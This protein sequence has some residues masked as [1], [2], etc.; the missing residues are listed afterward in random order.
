MINNDSSVSITFPSPAPIVYPARTSTRSAFTLVELLVVIAIIG[1]L[2]G[3]LL[4]A[5]QS[6]REA[7][8][9]TVCSNNMRQISLALALHESSRSEF[10]AGRNGCST[11]IGADQ[12]TPENPCG[13][14]TIPNPLCGASGFV[15]VLPFIEQT[16]LFNNLEVRD[17]GLWVDDISDRRWWDEAPQ[18][19]RDAMMF[20]PS[21]FVC[22]SSDSNE[23]SDV[24]AAIATSA[25]G[26]YA[27]CNGS[28][29]PDSDDDTVKYANDGLFLY[30]IP[31]RVA[32]I[33]QG[34]SNTYQAG[35]VNDSDIWESSSLWT[36]G[37][38]HADSLRSTRNPL[39]SLPGEGVVR[40][41]RNGA[42]GSRHPGGG[43]FA[44]ADGHVTFVVDEIESDVYQNAS[45]ITFQ[46]SP[47]TF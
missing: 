1:I 9:Q 45:S 20:R 3:M 28:L 26:T 17:G 35:E 37:R 16:S 42:F 13:R 46:T 32:S 38:I 34:L 43:F 6:V 29:G 5:V 39:N 40:Q 19:K 27:L 47:G 11:T 24:Y 25:T 41:R 15:A 12:P 7:A 2:V 44:F 33:S 14:L 36:Y 31:M 18:S 21:V 10:P 8:R 23:I 30:A 4:P 22:P